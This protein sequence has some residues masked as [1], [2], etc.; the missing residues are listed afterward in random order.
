MLRLEKINGKN[1]WDIL[2]LSVDDSQKTFV[3]SNEISIIEA[4]TAITAHGYA[5]PFGIYEGDTPIGFLMIGFDKDDYWED[6]PDIAIGNYNLW[7]LMI[8]KK[9]QHKGYGRQ[10][11]KLALNFIK[12]CPCGPAEYCWLSYEP[13]NQIAKEL[14]A[15]YGFVET[16]DMDGEEL[17]AVLKI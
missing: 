6:A 13:E 9:Y 10:A 4:Y 7:R 16:G 1:V 3:A 12:T 14:Y 15:S 5:Y 8:D 2:K 11:V 17:I